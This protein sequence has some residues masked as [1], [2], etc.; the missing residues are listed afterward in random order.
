VSASDA[1]LAAVALWVCTRFSRASLLQPLRLAA[2]FGTLLIASAAL[3]GCLRFAGSTSLL[4][5]HTSLSNQAAVIGLPLILI[6][7]AGSRLGKYLPQRI[8][9]VAAILLLAGIAVI[10]SRTA[11]AA[12]SFLLVLATLALSRPHRAV[13]LLMLL[14]LGTL[15]WL[16]KTDA[17]QN[18]WRLVLL[19]VAL[20]VLLPLSLAALRR[21]GLRE[22]KAVDASHRRMTI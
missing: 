9:A 12:V 13:P 4:P 19:H 16:A 14:C 21:T 22:V 1:V 20:A 11:S 7:V 17:L 6:A 8:S 10:Q 5:L 2:I 15:A 3:V 18:E